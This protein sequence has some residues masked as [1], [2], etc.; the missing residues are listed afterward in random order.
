LSS[1]IKVWGRRRTGCRRLV[2]AFRMCAGCWIFPPLR[3]S[4]PVRLPVPLPAGP[5]WTRGRRGGSFPVIPRCFSLKYTKYSCVKAPC[6]TGK[7]L[8]HPAFPF[9]NTASK[10]RRFDAW[11]V[12]GA[13]MKKQQYMNKKDRI[14]LR[15]ELRCKVPIA[16]I[17][18]ALG[19]SRRTIYSE[20]RRGAC[21]HTVD[22]RD[23]PR[24]SAD[25]GQAVQD[26]RRLR[27]GRELKTGKD[28]VRFEFLERKILDGHYP[29]AAALEL[30]PGGRALKLSSPLQML[31][32]QIFVDH[33]V[34]AEKWSDAAGEV[35]EYM[36]GDDRLR[37]VN[38]TGH[39]LEPHN[40]VWAQ[41][42]SRW[43][44]TLCGESV[45]PPHRLLR[46]CTN[47]RCTPSG[48]AF[49]RHSALLLLEIH[50]VFLCRSALIAGKIPRPSGVP[51]LS[52]Q[53][54][55][56]LSGN[57]SHGVKWE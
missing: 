13:I 54:L 22:Y 26:K 16:Q 53:V 7:S 50:K 10:I 2:S 8:T 29:P 51:R 47:R 45:K 3:L 46:T 18:R 9:M 14:R 27:K 11:E 40:G 20:I 12:C 19:F 21:L 31:I 37:D 55:R 4:G 42:V 5:E 15:E 43:T 48:R 36:V 35:L 24:C 23:R 34:A 33:V 44:T 52:V 32:S 49:S 57:A 28:R 38:H 6:L 30:E 17:A 41:A 25:R 39:G 56:N 1:Y